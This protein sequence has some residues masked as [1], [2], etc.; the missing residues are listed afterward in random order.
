VAT[1]FTVHGT[2]ASGPE[3]GDA[4]WQVGCEFEKDI[5]RLVQ[6]DDGSLR[7]KPI[8]WDGLNSELSR[9][10]AARKLA[11]EAGNLDK[12]QE[13]YAIVAHSHGGNIASMAATSARN[14]F[15]LASKIISVGTP[16]LLLARSRLLFS[17]VGLPA[18]AALV[19]IFT[20]VAV[21][22]T[23]IPP[24]VAAAGGYEGWDYWFATAIFMAFFAAPLLI[25]Y[26]G[27]RITDWWN[28]L[29]H[30]R[31]MMRRA[32]RRFGPRWV[33]LHDNNDEAIHG[34]A[35]AHKLD[36]RIFGSDFIVPALALASLFVI[37]LVGM[38]ISSSPEI[39]AKVMDQLRRNQVILL[40]TVQEE[41]LSNAAY[42]L[43]F[44]INSLFNLLSVDA[45]FPTQTVWRTLAQLSIVLIVLPA[46]LFALALTTT[47]AT[48]RLA[49]LVG[50][51]ASWVLNMATQHAIREAASGSDAT[52]KYSL[53]VQAH[54]H[55]AE[56]QLAGLPAALSK[57]V[58]DFANTAAAHA[59]PHLR[60]LLNQLAFSGG[61][62]EPGELAAKYLTWNELIH[63]SYFSVPRFRKFVCYLIANS[64]GFEPTEAFRDDP[65]YA[66]CE[67]WWQEMQQRPVAVARWQGA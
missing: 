18:K 14:R 8:I 2:F 26:G 53:G 59:V 49:R 62:G 10:A 15:K 4:W 17:R 22:L 66:Q 42:L 30:G 43:V 9:A 67:S 6:S 12:Q 63:T 52:G 36:V 34:L 60:S 25:V 45:F 35:S 19:S 1:I 39:M 33:C 38:W 58:N 13:R 27:L 32:R 7:I 54:P 61:A 11:E 55:W 3:Q 46:L 57:E 29:S 24:Y 64:E 20:M 28:F 41:S 21:F 40:S 48:V 65:D 23:I 51:V 5:R 50:W 31:W 37:P 16:Y 47:Y 44:C 56:K